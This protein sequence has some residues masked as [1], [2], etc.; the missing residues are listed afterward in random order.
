MIWTEYNGQRVLAT[1]VCRKRGWFVGRNETGVSFIEA[2]H[3]AFVWS[4]LDDALFPT[5]SEHRV[6]QMGQA[7]FG[8]PVQMTQDPISIA[9]LTFVGIDAVAGSV[10]V[11]VTTFLI[12]TAVS[13][14]VS[15]SRGDYDRG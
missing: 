6:M 11:A 15:I 13:R 14:G 5:I 7:G 12:T 3:V 9:V 2:N 1:V 4:V 10:A 8:R